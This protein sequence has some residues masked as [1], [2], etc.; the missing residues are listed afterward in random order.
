MSQYF[1]YVAH[2][3]HLTEK[4]SALILRLNNFY[5]AVGNLD[6]GRGILLNLDNLWKL[7]TAVVIAPIFVMEDE[8]R[9]ESEYVR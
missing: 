6:R 1:F 3:K 4:G 9:D 8:C 5:S 7:V 2:C